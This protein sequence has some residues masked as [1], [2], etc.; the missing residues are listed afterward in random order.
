MYHGAMLEQG[1]T[2]F[3]ILIVVDLK[4]GGRGGL[5]IHKEVVGFDIMRYPVMW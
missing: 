4:K 5:E 2:A 1:A 3:A